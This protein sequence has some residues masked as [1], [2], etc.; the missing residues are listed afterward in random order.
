MYLKAN[1][2]YAPQN[3]FVTKSIS[4]RISPT[5][6]MSQTASGTSMGYTGKCE[7]LLK[8]IST[9][10]ARF[11]KAF[12]KTLSISHERLVTYNNLDTIYDRVEGNT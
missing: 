3:S 11:A 6:E 4:S 10:L 1:E 2:R 5:F 7:K 8:F 12:H 9:M